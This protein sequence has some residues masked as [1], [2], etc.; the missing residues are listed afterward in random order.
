MIDPF[1]PLSGDELHQLEH[2]LLFDVDTDDVMTLE[3]ADGFLHAIAIGPTTVLPRQWLPKIWGTRDVMPPMSSA[4]QLNHILDLAM[5][6]YNGIIAG[7]E[8]DP[9]EIDPY[10]AVFDL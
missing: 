8:N 2:F 9:R 4:E 10:W 3:M 6:H 7:L 1:V 5:R